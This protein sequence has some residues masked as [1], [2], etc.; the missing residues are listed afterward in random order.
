MTAPERNTINIFVFISCFTLAV[1]FS[2]LI[3]ISPIVSLWL[4]LTALL[5]LLAEKVFNSRVCWE[6][7]L[8]S[9]VLLSFG[10]GSLRYAVKDFHT[11]SPELS[12]KVGG[13][14]E[15]V[16]IVVSE[17]AK[18]DKSTHLVM[19]T[20]GEKILVFADIYTN[21]LYGDE[22]RV[23]GTLKR[24]DKIGDEEEGRIFDYPKYL[25]KDDIYFL[26][27]FAD[28]EVLSSGHGNIIMRNLLYLKERIVESMRRILPEPEASLLAG[29]VVA[30]KGSLPKVIL[31][32]FRKAGI[33]HIVVLSG[34]NITIIADFIRK[35]FEALFIR[36]R[37]KLMAP[38]FGPQT[39]STLS[40]IGIILFVIMTG[41]EATV[42]RAS[43]MVLAVIGAKMFHRTYSAPRALLMAGFIM[44]LHNPKILVFD[45]SFQLSFLATCALIYVAPIVESRIGFLSERWGL[46]SVVATTIATQVTVL[47]LLM[48]SMGDVS[49]VSLPANVLVLL[50]IPATMFLGFLASIISFIIPTSLSVL[51]AFPAHFLLSWILGV[52]HVLGN[53]SFASIKLPPFSFF[54]VLVLYAILIL[55][56]VRSR[57]SSYRIAN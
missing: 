50:I 25:S 33:V 28:V 23:S 55:I 24:P 44:I 41:A 36:M 54:W 11:I 30:G 17:P 4:I 8:I 6:V 18:K 56:V 5:I 12:H 51:T 38:E 20:E 2:S 57:N 43:I 35:F 26:L 3:F 47:P 49:L 9:L 14:T 40:I 13:K 31:E 48:Y 53:M 37:P 1:L 15:L 21:A 45:P 46:R 10:L 52:S 32:E 19:E 16:G 22:V 29:L 39:A 7:F 42:V 34:Y 27:S